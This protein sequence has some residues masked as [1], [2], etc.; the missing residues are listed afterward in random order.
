MSG[1][2]I[3][4]DGKLSTAV[5]HVIINDPCRGYG[6]LLKIC[7]MRRGDFLAGVKL[8]L[9]ILKEFL[10]FV[11]MIQKKGYCNSMRNVLEYQ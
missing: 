3:I 4:Q 10:T 1:S 7:W 5:T 8:P 11:E 9:F 6:I 2:P